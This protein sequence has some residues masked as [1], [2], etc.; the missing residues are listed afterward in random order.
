MTFAPSQHDAPDSADPQGSVG[1]LRTP[2]TAGAWL[3]LALVVVALVALLLGIV[4]RVSAGSQRVD[5]L[6]GHAAPPF[7]L[8]SE[9]HG[10]AQ[11]GV[12]SLAS[13]RGSTRLLVFFYTLCSHCLGEL[14]TV[15]QT[16]QTLA[17]QSGSGFVPLYI[18]SPGENPAT[19][20]AYVTRV[21]IDTPVLLD[22]GGQVAARYGIAYYPTIVLVDGDGI[23][24]ATW[25]G[26]PDV[27]T[28]VS[29]IRQVG[30]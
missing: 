24:R 11:P 6:V 28:L 15:A 3:R 19:A 16:Q 17:Q 29:A 23:V 22:G 30:G 7:A 9:V 5:A 1:R 26:E 27:A 20:D 13:S 8:T 4:S 25:T 18:D 14:A 21:G 12:T 10:Q 2:L